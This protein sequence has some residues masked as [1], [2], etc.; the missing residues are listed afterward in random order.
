[1]YKRFHTE[2]PDPLHVAITERFI[3]KWALLV[4]CSYT[5]CIKMQPFPNKT[6]G[7]CFKAHVCF[8]KPRLKPGIL[9]VCE[10][11]LF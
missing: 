3:L 7:M 11:L 6:S 4:L 2:F 10:I 5:Q 9:I 8:M 1:M